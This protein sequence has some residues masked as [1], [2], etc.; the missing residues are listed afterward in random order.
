MAC[1]KWHRWKHGGDSGAVVRMRQ[2]A[3]HVRQPATP[4]AFGENR[5]SF[6]QHLDQT[7]I[8][9]AEA[10]AIKLL[11]PG[12]SRRQTFLDIG[13]GSGL[14]T[15]AAL[16]LGAERVLALDLDPVSVRTTEKMLRD[17]LTDAKW[18]VR[19]VSIFDLNPLA[20]ASSTSSVPG[21]CSIILATWI[22]L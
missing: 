9:A 2:P 16:R 11:G 7:K 12:A 5:A 3:Q 22:K 1:E 20:T 15:L 4:F 14:H 21:L 6:A 10:E 18:R 13:C 19:H 8:E 17:N